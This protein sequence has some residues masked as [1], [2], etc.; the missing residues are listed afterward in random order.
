MTDHILVCGSRGQV[1]QALAETP[2][3]EGLSFVARGRPELDLLQ[4]DSVKAALEDIRP[5]L[6]VN[7][8]AYTAVD[9]AESDED[10]AHALNAAAPGELARLCAERNSPLIHLSTDY[11]FDGSKDAPYTEDDPVNPLGVYGRTKRAGE[12]AVTEANPDSLILRTAWVYSP[13]GKNFCKTML[14]VGNQRDELGVVMDQIGN[15]TS[16]HDIAEAIAKITTAI[17]IDGQPVRAGIYHLSGTGEASW[18]DFAS[19]IFEESAASGGPSAKVNRITSAEFPTPVTRPANSRLDGSKLQD[20][21]GITIP[22]WR[23]SMRVCVNK[24]V[25]TGAWTS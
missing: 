25:E 8:A 4:P 20:A 15:P 11:V 7:A 23:E 21:Y 3:P 18:A 10:A 19:A 22:H 13:F 24:L 16:A 14:R 12:V 9:Q 17:L 1:A 2:L 6:V 5:K